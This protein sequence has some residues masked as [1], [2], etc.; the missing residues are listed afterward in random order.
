[1]FADRQTHELPAEPDARERIALALG[2]P[3]CA[4]LELE[5]DARRSI[6]MEEFAALMAPGQRARR[7]SAGSVWSDVWRRFASDGVDAQA[8]A[9]HGFPQAD[10]AATALAGLLGSSALRAMSARARERLDHL[11]PALLAAAAA[12]GDPLAT[13]TRLLDLVQAVARRSVYLALLNEQPAALKRLTEVFSAS[14]F[15]AAQV[16]RHPLLLDELFD[17]RSDAAQLDA[18]AVGTAI[19][20]RIAV[21]PGPDPEAEIESIQEERLAALFRIGLAFLGARIDAI[22]AARSLAEVAE[23]VLDAVLR[24][25]ERDMIAA[26]GHVD[27]RADNGCGLAVIAYGSLGAAELGF[28]SDLDLVF[29]YDAALGARESDGPRPLDGAR[30]YTRLAQRVVH[31]LTTPLRSGRL[32][33]IDVRLRPDGGTGLLVTSLD[34]FVAYQTGRAWIWER[35]ALVRARSVAGDVALSRRFATARGRCL[36]A[37]L[38][39]ADG[40]VAKSD[41]PTDLHAE[42]VAMRS[43]WRTERDRSDDTLFDL[44]Q[45]AG[46][47]VDIEFLLQSLVLSHGGRH[48]SLL[49]SGNTPALIGACVVAGVLDPSHG[50][51]LAAAHAVLLHRALART[52]DARPRV[53]PRT[54]EL[55]A[56]AAAVL[57]A[58]HACGFP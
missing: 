49:A 22:S 25:A 50:E 37:P 18:V 51:S 14:A 45:G 4:Q 52:L 47:L 29:V 31:L 40:S 3:D 5:L 32:Y 16:A 54:P 12:T 15:L 8:L 46:G 57:A 44:K 27:R 34:A 35:Q 23:A 7:A 53:V 43:R 10:A 36:V 20:R 55:E 48:P 2:Y 28:A 39:T 21:L 1:M 58:V 19:A 17:D 41:T 38:G 26:H 24:I 33:E 30:Y 56:H 9:E 13:L 11:M 42:I 6:V